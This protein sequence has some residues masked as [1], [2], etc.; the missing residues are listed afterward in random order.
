MATGIRSVTRN[1]KDIFVFVWFVLLLVKKDEVNS[2]KCAIQFLRYPP[3]PGNPL[4]QNE[5]QDAIPWVG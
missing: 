3:P 5:N 1:S 4:D 2:I